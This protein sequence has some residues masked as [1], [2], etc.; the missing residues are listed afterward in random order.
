MSKMIEINGRGLEAIVFDMDGLL[1]DSEKVVQ[2][3]WSDVSR[4][5]GVEDAGA[6]IYNT[7]GF[8]IV[9]RRTY[10]LDTFGENFPFE[11]FADRT[12]IRF[13]DIAQAEGIER[14][15]GVMEL[16]EF[17]KEHGVRMAV[18]TSS[19]REHAEE[20]L[21]TGGIYQYFD[22]FVFGDSVKNAKPDPEI[23]LTA[24]QRLGADPAASL[25][26][27]DSPAGIESA[28]AAGMMPVMIPDLV[29]PS[30]EIKKLCLGWYPSLLD[31]VEVL[32]GRE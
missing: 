12:R 2:R 18:A 32:H 21:N 8:N 3:S 5:M 14:K 10:F 23:Y 15:P 17:A 20:M 13:H 9:R 19:R 24:C 25:A 7:I 16:L 11:E 29:A 27:E 22:Q 31:V 28:Y 30:E 26:L 1:F 6:H 4:D